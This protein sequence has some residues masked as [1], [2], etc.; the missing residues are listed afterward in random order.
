MID[1]PDFLAC[2]VS[3]LAASK[4]KSYKD[5]SRLAFCHRFSVFEGQTPRRPSQVYWA[6][7]HDQSGSRVSQR[8]P[9][10]AHFRDAGQVEIQ[11]ARQ[12]NSRYSSTRVAAEMP[13]PRCKVRHRTA[14]QKPGCDVAQ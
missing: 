13:P 12:G 6:W 7:R 4:R 5:C 8:L 10:L 1:S 2:R 11:V 9:P 14:Q 3:Y